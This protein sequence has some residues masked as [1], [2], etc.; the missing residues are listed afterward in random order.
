MPH[1]IYL[2]ARGGTW[3]KLGRCSK[4]L[5]VLGDIGGITNAHVLRGDW[6]EVQNSARTRGIACPVSAK[7]KQKVLPRHAAEHESGG[8][9]REVERLGSYHA[10]MNAHVLAERRLGP[11]AIRK[12]V[13][14]LRE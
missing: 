13:T 7:T 9:G 10:I 3:V 1:R 4:A 11:S 5:A 8:G 2:V 6:G 14:T 12:L